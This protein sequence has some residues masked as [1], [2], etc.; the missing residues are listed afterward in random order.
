WAR[1]SPCSWRSPRLAGM[2]TTDHSPAHDA[3]VGDATVG[4]AARY[5]EVSG[6]LPAR[7]A[8]VGG[9]RMG[10]GIAHAFLVRGSRVVLVEADPERAE[11]ARD[12][13]VRAL[14]RSVE[15]GTAQAPVGQMV[16]QLRVATDL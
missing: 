15:R 13:V 16:E 14:H 6:A 7:V 11:P 12:A 3:A 5:D 10:T 4:D 8:V 2:P 9:G 1:G